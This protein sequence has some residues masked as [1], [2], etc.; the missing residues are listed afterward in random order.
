LNIVVDSNGWISYFASD[1]KALIYNSLIEAQPKVPT[2]VLYEVYRWSLRELGQEKAD[3]YA[4]V[5]QRCGILTLTPTA[6]VAGAVAAHR[7]KLPACDALIYAICQEN[8]LQ[9]ATSD[10]D[11]KGL[12][13]VIYHP[14]PRK[15]PGSR[16]ESRAA[17]R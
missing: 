11:L 10:E 15:E 7:Y 9:L 8:K 17:R 16:K 4:V 5:M 3:A 6:S 12:P 13:D 1:E 2:I 14:D